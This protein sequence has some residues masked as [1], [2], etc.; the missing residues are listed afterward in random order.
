MVLVSRIAGSF[1]WSGGSPRAKFAQVRPPAYS[2][3][4]SKGSASS[5]RPLSPYESKPQASVQLALLRTPF[6]VIPS[7]SPSPYFYILQWLEANGSILLPVPNPTLQAFRVIQPLLD[8]E[9][10]PIPVRSISFRAEL[11]RGLKTANATRALNEFRCGY[12]PEMVNWN[13]RRERQGEAPGLCSCRAAPA[14]TP[15]RLLQVKRGTQPG[16]SD[17]S[18]FTPTLPIGSFEATRIKLLSNRSLLQKL[19]IS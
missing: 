2:L 4:L 1:V 15:K 11:G 8:A 12:A 7:T 16:R 19:N 13:R 10:G 3:E 5:A 17:P 14:A 18:K 6:L 9:C